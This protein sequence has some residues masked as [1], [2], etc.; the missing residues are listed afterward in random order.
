MQRT[1]VGLY[2][3]YSSLHMKRANTQAQNNP[4]CYS[5][6]TAGDYKKA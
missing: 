6:Y 4:T 2:V 5:L 1:R 3:Y